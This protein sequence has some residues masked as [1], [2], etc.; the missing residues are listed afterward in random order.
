[1][2]MVAREFSVIHLPRKTCKACNNNENMV[3]YKCVDRN[4]SGGKALPFGGVFY[5]AYFYGI[6]SYY[7]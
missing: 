6:L 3:L 2:R 1:M 5:F 4:H 7:R